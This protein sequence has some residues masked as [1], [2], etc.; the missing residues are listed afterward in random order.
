MIG[1][2]GLYLTLWQ[3]FIFCLLIIVVYSIIKLYLKIIKYLN[4]KIEVIEEQ[5]NKAK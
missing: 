3:I 4:L 5:R 1:T 2:T